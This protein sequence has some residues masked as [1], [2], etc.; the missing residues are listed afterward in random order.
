M[1]KLNKNIGR[2]ME[3]DIIVKETRSA[4]K[5]TYYGPHQIT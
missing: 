3:V 4:Q 2:Q 5:G 1:D